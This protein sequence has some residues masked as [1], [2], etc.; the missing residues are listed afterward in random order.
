MY[1]DSPD[2]DPTDYLNTWEEKLSSSTRTHDDPTLE[3]R[4]SR[5]SSQERYTNLIPQISKSSDMVGSYAG[6]GK[7]Q[8]KIFQETGR[9]TCC[10][11]GFVRKFADGTNHWSDRRRLNI[12]AESFTCLNYRNEF[13][14][15]M[16]D[17]DIRDRIFKGDK[18][19]SN[20]LRTN[21]DLDK[22]LYCTFPEEG[23][24]SPWVDDLHPYWGLGCP[25]IP[26]TGDGPDSYELTQPED[27]ILADAN[28]RPVYSGRLT[29]TQAMITIRPYLPVITYNSGSPPEVDEQND[30]NLYSP[31]LHADAPFF[32]MGYVD[33]GN[34]IPKPD[35]DDKEAAKN[36][37]KN[38]YTVTYHSG[39]IDLVDAIW[40]IPF[41]LP[42]I[43][44]VSDTGIF[45]PKYDSWGASFIVP[46]YVRDLD[47]AS[48]F[49]NYRMVNGST[50]RDSV[51]LKQ[52]NDADEWPWIGTDK[53]YVKD[54]AD[55]IGFMNASPDAI[56]E[57]I[58]NAVD[59]LSGQTVILFFGDGNDTTE[60]CRN[61]ITDTCV[62]VS[63][64]I[65]WKAPNRSGSK[66]YATTDMNCF[67]STQTSRCEGLKPGSPYFYLEKLGRFELLGIPQIDY[68]P[69]V[70]N[71]NREKIVPG[72]FEHNGMAINTM[73]GSHDININN[74]SDT[75]EKK[76]GFADISLDNIPA[77]TGKA[78]YPSTVH[79]FTINPVLKDNVSMPDIFS[80]NEFL[81]CVKL[82]EV[83]ETAANCCSGHAIYV[84]QEKPEKGFQC[85]LPYGANLNVYF[86]R[87][88]S[89]DG[90][91]ED[92]ILREDE[93]PIGFILDQ[94]NLRTGEIIP[95]EDT[96]KILEKLGQRYCTGDSGNNPQYED[97]IGH[98][99]RR[100]SAVG[101]YQGGPT[102]FFTYGY[103]HPDHEP[104][105]NSAGTDLNYLRMS[106]VDHY[107]DG[108]NR[109]S[110]ENLEHHRGYYPYHAGYRWNHHFYCS[111]VQQ[112]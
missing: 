65:K 25:Q 81:C 1:T 33:S 79:N 41:A 85:R 24:S 89:S 4:Y 37:A 32:P 3:G 77:S 75:D 106:F 74:L 19:G 13:A 59:A 108:E 84:D 53:N 78:A 94:F 110:N 90:L 67:Q 34:L 49:I 15:A 60:R 70:C 71:S 6:G 97:S 29:E 5:Y 109:E 38:N 47:E 46:S 87:F 44:S 103:Q 14:E 111:G 7:P 36:A 104:N 95:S 62:D 86:N 72:I 61:G 45:A 18:A 88:V 58:C 107:T 22:R 64:T 40:P 55:S 80:E 96:D 27:G 35:S 16:T 28:N 9:N 82:G 23:A 42:Y 100:G 39:L 48:F 21:F 26:L 17:T 43:D 68:E 112:N 12:P 52:C 51:N 11:N 76:N 56:E 69:L 102:A 83:S 105:R 50:L 31:H 73:R 10:G 20:D 92:S 2:S 99:V 54:G 57:G 93:E 66:Y 101:N 8:W 63:I 91:L 98:T 30:I